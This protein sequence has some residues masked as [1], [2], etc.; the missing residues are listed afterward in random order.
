MALKKRFEM[1]NDDQHDI[2]PVIHRWDAPLT[3]N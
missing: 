1:I 3:I 2:L